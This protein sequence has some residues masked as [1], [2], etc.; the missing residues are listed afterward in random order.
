M[1]TPWDVQRVAIETVTA[2]GL[3]EG[4]SQRA[5]VT[6]GS[7]AVVSVNPPVGIWDAIKIINTHAS[8]VLT[9]AVNE[10]PSSSSGSLPG[11]TW[12]V[13]QDIPPGG[14]ELIDRVGVLTTIRLLSDTDGTV[15][16]LN[17]IKKNQGG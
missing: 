16:M 3:G 12:G 10:D 4:T 6:V 9:V 15:V 14:V 5:K 13:G 1:G 8:A 17:L 11:V 7:S 2:G